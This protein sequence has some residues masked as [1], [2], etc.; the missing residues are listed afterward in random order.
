MESTEPPSPPPPD[1]SRK[2]QRLCSRGSF[3]WNHCLETGNSLCFDCTMPS[4]VWHSGYKWA[5][6]LHEKNMTFSWA[7]VSSLCVEGGINHLVKKVFV[8]RISK[9]I[10]VLIWADRK[11]YLCNVDR[12]L[13]IKQHTWFVHKHYCKMPRYL[14][15]ASHS[16][17]W[18]LSDGILFLWL[19]STI[20][21]P[22]TTTNKGVF[23]F[24]SFSFCIDLHNECEQKS[25]WVLTPARTCPSVR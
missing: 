11:C 20:E 19:Y 7:I 3:L 4:S 1:G 9:V 16:W 10:I 25:T 23:T 13:L 2:T 21:I 12:C 22:L 8:L 24:H 14:S 6:G 18:M 15:D 5:K 17:T